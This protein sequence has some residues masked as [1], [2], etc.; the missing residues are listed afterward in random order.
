MV[1]SKVR[2]LS[3]RWKALKNMKKIRLVPS[4]SRDLSRKFKN[5]EN[6]VSF[7]PAGLPPDDGLLECTFLLEP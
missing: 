2:V 7:L 3:R 6:R 1:R 4:N 5:L